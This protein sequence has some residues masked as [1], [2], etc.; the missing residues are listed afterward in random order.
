MA[1]GQQAKSM[2]QKPAGTEGSTELYVPTHMPIGS[3][4]RLF[5]VL[6]KIEDGQVKMVPRLTPNGVQMREGNK[7]NGTP[8]M[9]AEP[10][11][12]VGFL[13]AWWEVMVNGAKKPRRLILEL[14]ERKRWTN[15]LWLHIKENFEKGSPQWSSIKTAFA[16]NVLDK[17]QVFVDNGRVWYRSESGFNLMP[18]GDKGKIEQ[19]KEKLP[20]VSA[21]EVG[22]PLMQIR[23]LEGSY[24]SVNPP[25][26]HLF[27]QLYNLATE[28]EDGD[29]MIRSLTEFDV[30][31]TTTTGKTY[32]DTSRSMVNLSKFEAT[33]MEYEL[34]PR[35]DLVSWLKP[36]P[37]QAIKDLIDGAD[38]DTVIKDYSITTQP[39]LMIGGT[40]ETPFDA[41]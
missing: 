11:Q 3:G 28:V 29:G 24:G 17:S 32:Q 19:D 34:M 31:L 25:G 12:E 26:K 2:A 7:K 18:Y 38:Y 16:L 33:P 15:P 36:W 23:I 41:D 6:S 10:D 35:Y 22:T 21:D 4:R 20:K 40:D 8:L 5:R 39:K 13:Y 27:Q 14:D 37:D 9:V 30:K 1:F